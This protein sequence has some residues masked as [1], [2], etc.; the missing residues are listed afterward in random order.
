M[1][2]R[3]NGVLSLVA[4]GQ[5]EE[6]NDAD[7]AEL[8]FETVARGDARPLDAFFDARVFV[9]FLAPAPSSV[10]RCLHC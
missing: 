1:Y 9:G 6:G 5:T 7:L 8:A 4:R 10:A 3:G 2:E